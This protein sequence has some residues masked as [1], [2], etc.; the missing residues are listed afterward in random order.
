MSIVPLMHVTF[1]GLSTDKDRLLDELQQLG[2]MELIPLAGDGASQARG[3]TSRARQALMFLLTCPQHRRQANDASRF[4]AVDVENRALA[5]QESIQTLAAQRD[6]LVQRLAAARPWGDFRFPHHDELAGKRLWFYAVPFK[7][8]PL[9]ESCGLAWQVVRRDQ[10]N[11]YV[12]VVSDSEPT[13]LPAP[14][15]HLGPMSPGDAAQRLEEVELAIE[16][17]QAERAYLTRWCLLFARSLDHLDSLADRQDAASRTCD[18]DPLFAVQSWAPQERL[19]ELADCARRNR[20]AFETRAP[21]SDERPPTWMRNAPYVAAGEDLVNFYMT[22]GYWTWDPSGVVAASFAVF[23]AMILADAGYAAILALWLLFVWKRLGRSPSGQR[24]RP[25]LIAI[26]VASLAYGAL[27]GSYFG[28]APPQGSLLDGIHLLD[29]NNAS[30]MMGVSVLVGGVHVALA[31]IMD[32]RRHTSWRDGL[33]SVGWASAVVG[34]MIVGAAA[35][36]MAAAPYLWVG[37]G[38]VTIGLLLVVAYTAPQERWVQRS[39]QGVLGLTRLSSA[40]GDVLS[41]LRL[42]A[43]GLASA[44]L[45]VAFNDMAAGVRSASPRLGL[46]LAVVVLILGHGLNLLLGVSSGV[47]H[48]LRLNVIEFFNWGLKDEGR[49]FA[50]FRRKEESSW[51]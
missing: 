28:V 11:C 9:V 21:T 31:N 47:I 20:V 48:G 46:I 42:F 17:A 32:A 10:R 35:A 33:A 40:F 8:M 22:P 41:Y 2:C 7:S 36:G 1:V 26:V 38:L 49:R 37:G 51:K 29:M 25:L 4:D 30:L 5:L 50:P 14:R 12:V 6:E 13:S 24:F 45:A 23:F 39:V 43:L 27:V 15:S 3:S 34:G 18:I 19:A 16:D 44:S